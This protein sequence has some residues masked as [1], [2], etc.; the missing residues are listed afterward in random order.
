M[1]KIFIG[2]FAVTIA[3]V[4]SVGVV[5]AKYEAKIR[6]HTIAGTVDV[7]GLPPKE[8]ARRLR[9]WWET[10]RIKP[11]HVKSALVHAALPDMTPGQLGVSL[12]DQRTVDALPKQEIVEAAQSAVGSS[13][14]VSQR[15]DLKWRSSGADLSHLG[16][17]VADAAGNPHA[18]RVAFVNGQIVRIPEVSGFKLDLPRLQDAVVAALQSGGDVELPI[19]QSPK[20]VSDADLNQITDVVTE[21]HTHF[22]SRQG[23][24]NNNIRVASGKLSGHVLMPGQRFSFNE[25]VG[26]RTIDAGFKE[27]GVYKN[28]RHDHGVG[29]GI[30]QVSTT[31]YNAALFA[32]LKIDRRQN[33]SMPV[34][35]V[36]IG[37]DATVDYGSIDLVIEN[38]YPTPIAVVSDFKP[39]TLTFRILGKK[40]PSLSV[41]LIGVGHRSWDRGIKTTVDNHL[42][43]GRKIVTDK[44][45]Q[46]HFVRTY[47][48]VYKNG[49]LVK[50]ESLGASVY[51][52]GVRLV[53]VG[54]GLKPPASVPV[55]P[56]SV[57]H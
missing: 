14:G 42:K 47:R 4:A 21:F 7:G 55:A 40:D 34:A 5:V 43:P 17:I 36:P 48:L 23:S 11:L 32:N 33:H 50:K 51:Q 46:G 18:A 16:R 8:A 19:E 12:D 31:L 9:I 38:S 49:V 24:R 22:P 41:K 15:F 39:G 44:G 28:G 35:Y 45:S 1:N 26:K 2:G 53:S 29:G 25:T 10:E 6:P 30:C 57:G 52:G 56:P 54:P 13:D 3:S 37:R 20:T 27:A